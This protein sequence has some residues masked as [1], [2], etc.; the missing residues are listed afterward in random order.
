MGA[1]VEIRTHIYG[2]SRGDLDYFWVGDNLDNGAFIQFGYSF[3]PGYGCLQGEWNGQSFSCYGQSENIGVSDA[4]W[5]WQ[6][7]PNGQGK[8]FY[9]GKGPAHSA[10]L[11]GSWHTYS[12]MP[13]VANGW[14]FVL[15]GQPV[16][17]MDN[18]QWTQSRDP[19]HFVA[20]KATNSPNFGN[21]GPV[22]FRNLQYLKSDGWHSVDALYAIRACAYG[23]QCVPD[24][25]Y[26]VKLEEPNQVMAGS[27]QDKLQNGAS[28]W[29]RAYFLTLTVP[30][31]VQVV[32]DGTIHNPGL[33]ELALSPGSHM[34]SV[35]PFVQTG[36]ETGLRFVIWSD[37]STSANRI[38]D[39]TSECF[40]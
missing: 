36:T 33:I 40:C 18:F 23:A 9:A 1:S 30:S 6:Y 39:L 7:W 10:G 22:E 32:V 25:P 19:V 20:E 35:P 12:I 24:I 11:D 15:D 4:R 14:T 37:G 8:V 38:I 21:L 34:L 27:G 3:E 29:A 28:L 31:E 26:G 2:A 5:E 13:N 16:A 17:S